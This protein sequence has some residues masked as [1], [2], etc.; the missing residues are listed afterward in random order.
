MGIRSRGQV[1]DGFNRLKML[2]EGEISWEQR[3]QPNSKIK[4]GGGGGK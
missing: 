1:E 2:A 4:F 3:E